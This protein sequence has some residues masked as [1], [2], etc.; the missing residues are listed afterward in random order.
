M[1]LKNLEMGTGHRMLVNGSRGVVIGFVD[2]RVGSAG[3][4]CTMGPLSLLMQVTT[5]LHG[6]LGRGAL[7]CFLEYVSP[8]GS[9][10]HSLELS[11]TR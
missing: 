5:C 11:S 7:Q 8:L 2:K 4:M 9:S 3:L 6:R 10:I 1:L